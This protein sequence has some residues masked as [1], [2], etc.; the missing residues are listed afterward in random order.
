MHKY[1]IEQNLTDLLVGVMLT[2]LN[3]NVDKTKEMI[4]DYHKNNNEINGKVVQTVQ[5]YK[6]LG[7]LTNKKLCFESNVYALYKKANSRL[8]FWRKLKELKIDL[9]I[10]IL[11]YTSA[12]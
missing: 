5:E 1:N 2:F 9:S 11:F 6:Y 10:I 7:T 8:Y 4:I 12:I 3:L